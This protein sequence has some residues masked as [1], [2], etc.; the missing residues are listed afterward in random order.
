MSEQIFGN[1]RIV[2]A[3]ECFVGTVV[4]AEGRIRELARGATAV[5][6]AQDWGGDWLLPGLVEVHT[7]NLEKHLIPRPGVIWNAHSALVAHD[8]QCAAAGI[9]TVLDAVVIGNMDR[10]GTRSRTQHA[11]IAALGE[12]AD[13]GLL[14]VEHRLHLRCEVTAHD[15]VEVFERYADHER[16]ALVSVMDHT[17]GQRQWRDLV[18]YRRY[19]ERHGSV[20]DADF[21][22]LVQT[23]IEEQHQYAD[24]H[25]RAIVASAHARGVPLAS[26]DDTEIEQVRQ[27]QAEG[28]ELAEFPTTVHAAQAARAAGIG[29]IMGGPNLV[30]GGSH[31]GNVS[32]AALAQRDLLD[33]FS[34]DYVPASL[35]Q[36]AF[37]LHDQLGW[38]LPR[39]TAT[40]ARNPAR[41]LGLA[42]RGEIAPGLRAD[43][44]RVRR[45][46]GMPV[47]LETWVEGRRAV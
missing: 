7:D 26:H 41:A 44:I 30:Q 5:P 14:R 18:K 23:L 37:L 36:S 11:A 4:V 15:I 17:P 16:L 28:I 35:L 47:V 9:T 31:S 6:A 20:S 33:I 39:A 24:A 29:I 8:T 42:D 46:A 40:V 13:E 38:S 32:A 25:R 34:S 22:R 1:A 3:D 45:S 27:A 12:C 2:A 19:A 21:E 43:F 10:G